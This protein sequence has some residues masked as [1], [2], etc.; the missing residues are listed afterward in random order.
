M[1]VFIDMVAIV[2]EGNFQASG[3]GGTS[4]GGWWGGASFQ[5]VVPYYYAT[6]AAQDTLRDGP[7]VEIDRCI[8]NNMVSEMYHFI[9]RF[10]SS[11]SIALMSSH[12]PC[13]SIQILIMTRATILMLLIDFIPA[14][15]SALPLEYR[16]TRV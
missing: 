3:W 10:F 2:K 5:G 14:L 1:A 13:A 12:L 4:I 6:R 8:Y 11:S 9:R 7:A 16:W 15:G